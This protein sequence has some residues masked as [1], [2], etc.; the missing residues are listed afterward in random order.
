[1]QGKGPRRPTATA[2]AALAAPV[3]QPWVPWVLGL[4][5]GLRGAGAF[6]C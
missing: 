5:L 4:I 2:P 6:Q 3:S 1:V